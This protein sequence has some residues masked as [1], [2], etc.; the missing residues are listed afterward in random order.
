MK[1]RNL[2]VRTAGSTWLI[3]IWLAAT[4]QLHGQSRI[5]GE[6]T[7]GFRALLAGKGL[8]AIES[9][10]ELDSFVKEDA[11][12][13]LIVAFH[14]ANALGPRKD[15]LDEIPFN[16]RRQFIE[17]GG[18]LFV[19]SDQ[20]LSSN[21]TSNFNVKIVGGFVS[22]SRRAGFDGSYDCPYIAYHRGAR[23]DLFESPEG[24][25]KRVATNK[26]SSL[27]FPD[28]DIQTLA[29]FPSNTWQRTGDS[30]TFA[31]LAFAQGTSYPGGGR[32]LVLADHSIFINSMML[33][34][35]S[36]NDNLQFAS[37]C[38]DWLIFGENG[39]RTHVIFLE[40]E[41]IWQRKDYDLSLQSLPVGPDEIADYLWQNKDILW[42][43]PEVADAL[44]SEIE[45]S[46]FFQE[47]ERA[48]PFNA[49]LSQILPQI[50]CGLLIIG[51]VAL[52]SYAT[53]SFINSRRAVSRSSPRLATVLGQLRPRTGLLDQ[54]VRNGIGHGLFDELA[55]RQAREMFAE[56]DLT[57]ADGAPAPGFTID[58]P[59]WRRGRIARDLR[60]AWAIA[61]D[62]NAVAMS[63]RRRE[64]WPSRLDRLGAMIRDHAI[65]IG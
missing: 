7:H 37:N 44:V 57:P 28:S 24:E 65:R 3:L 30:R 60:L 14:G 6:G 19:A 64:Q 39:Q 42:K 61:F 32:L 38:I 59:W 53:I 48:D 11:S 16:L 31:P 27:G 20:P 25:L 54:R 18:A 49:F 5:T 51:A 13:V 56:L 4:P 50:L 62:A 23:P 10:E 15:P 8:T 21:L 46:G 29:E 63:T 58:A 9:L 26:P 22:A 33:P 17:K 52:G 43:H 12:R 35:Y 55:R 36:S 34:R 45:Q 41:K 40:D 2:M 47:I 1:V